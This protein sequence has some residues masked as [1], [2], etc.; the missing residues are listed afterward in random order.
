E[1]TEKTIAI[2]IV[3]DH[4]LFRESLVRLLHAERGFE[5]VAHCGSIPVT[6]RALKVP[7]VW[8]VQSTSLPDF[9]EKGRG[10]TNRLRPVPIKAI[11]DRSIL[12][13]IKI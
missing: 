12:A 5:V 2:L 4:A 7:L 6:C 3:D 11:A 8:V 13:F 1:A 9:F 10:M